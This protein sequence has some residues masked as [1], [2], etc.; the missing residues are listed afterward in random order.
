MKK[1]V[2]LITLIAVLIAAVAIF[3]GCT[4]QNDSGT[5][6]NN[7]RT[8]PMTVTDDLGNKI[9]LAAQPTKIIS[10]ALATDEILAAVADKS[11]LYGLSTLSD[12]KYYSNIIEFAATIPHK[13]AGKDL[14]KLI[15]AKPDLVI[16]ASWVDARDLSRLKAAG[17]PTYAAKL[18]DTI[19][20]IRKLIQNIGI[21]TGN[22]DRAATTIATMDKQLQDVTQATGQIPPEQRLNALMTDN[23]FYVFGENSLSAQLLK[24]AN[25]NNLAAKI[26]VTKIDNV[27]KERIVAVDPQALFISAYSTEDNANP[28]AVYLNDKSFANV[29]AVKNH[30]VFVINNPHLTSMSQFIALGAA[31]IAR[32]AYPDVKF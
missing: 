12:D 27:S 22:S 5:L 9:V 11:A 31:D 6:P 28:A 20:D 14:E 23:L 30:K 3:P 21:I 18:P 32:A 29:R 1:L 17:I 8:F 13:F 19:D 15:Q 10:L 16:T 26:G 7:S 24:I 25:I 2:Y 4:K